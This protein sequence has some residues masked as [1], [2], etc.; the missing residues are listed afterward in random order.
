MALEIEHKYLVD[1]NSFREM[2][3]RVIDIRQGY[4]S[5]DADST[6]RIRTAGNHAFLTVKTR[7]AGSARNEF[8]YEIP[9]DDGVELLKIC[10]GEII[11]KDRYIV[12]YQGYTWE[13][14]VFKGNL[15][16]ISLAEIELPAESTVYP[17]PPFAGKNVTGMPE[18]YNSNIHKLVR[19]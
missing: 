11:E 4:I 16:G 8:E 10:K 7:N 18:Y 6:V 5:R 12:D 15:E 13:V 14:D 19:R 9:F 1:N 17:T 2:A 3:S